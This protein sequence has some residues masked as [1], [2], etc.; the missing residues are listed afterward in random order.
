M[1]GIFSIG[2]KKVRPGVYYRRE[3]VGGVDV[4]GATN[5]VGAAIFTS[6]WG[7]LN[8]VVDLD[9]TMQNNLADYYGNGTTILRELFK[10]GATTVRAVR[11]GEADGA[12]A[13]VALSDAAGAPAITLAAAYP[14]KRDFAVSVRT[15]LATGKRKLIVYD[16]T[17]IFEQFTFEAGADEIPGAGNTKKSP[18]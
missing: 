16:G 2:E 6:N 3:N 11:V 9:I 12:A 18:G 8:E 15:D 1:S 4:V 5:G 13:T 17:E 14:G 7:P 10:G